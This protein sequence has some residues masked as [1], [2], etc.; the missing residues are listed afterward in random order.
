VPRFPRQAPGRV[1][2]GAYDRVSWIGSK[3]R[4]VLLALHPKDVYNA[5]FH[6]RL[7]STVNEEILW[8]LQRHSK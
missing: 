2:T 1:G 7:T 4:R 3:R 5:C 8:L 6:S